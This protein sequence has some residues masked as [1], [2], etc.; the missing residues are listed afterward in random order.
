M[1]I[2]LTRWRDTEAEEAAFTLVA[3][4]AEDINEVAE[5]VGYGTRLGG[6][7]RPIIMGIR[8]NLKATSNEA[9]V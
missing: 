1:F 4:V 7:E 8:V 5:V 6:E 2:G 3:A 9:R